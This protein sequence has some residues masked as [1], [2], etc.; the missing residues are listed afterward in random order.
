MTHM[1]WSMILIEQTPQADGS[2][3][4]G[5]TSTSTGGKNGGPFDIEGYLG[6]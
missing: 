6:Q 5:R 3:R 2:S 4:L 1:P